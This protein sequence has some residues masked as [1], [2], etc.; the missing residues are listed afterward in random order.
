M[1]S[2]QWWAAVCVFHFCCREAREKEDRSE[3]KKSSAKNMYFDL[4]MQ[5]KLLPPVPQSKEKKLAGRQYR[6]LEAT[7]EWKRRPTYS[8]TK[9]H[10]RLNIDEFK[11][12][13]STKWQRD[14]SKRLIILQLT[15]SSKKVPLVTIFKF[16]QPSIIN[17]RAN[18]K[19]CVQQIITST[20]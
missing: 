1:R 2:A 5:R 3:R 17:T 18:N 20:Y 6:K 9:L 4:G 13:Y 11:P 12:L 15:A 16:N 7:R 8:D 10:S 14:T 19:V